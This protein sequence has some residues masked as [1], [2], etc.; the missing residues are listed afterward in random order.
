MAQKLRS[1]QEKK[2]GKVNPYL[3]PIRNKITLAAKISV[4]PSALKRH[5]GFLFLLAGFLSCLNLEARAEEYRPQIGTYGG[6][7]VFS[8]TSDPKSFN[9]I[10]AKETST[11]AVTGLIFEGLTRTNGIT[12]EVE[13]NLALSWKV[14]ESG[15]KWTFK[16]REDV[17]WFDGQRFTADDVV[18]TFNQLIYSPDIPNSA[19]D[20]FTVE[21]KTFKVEKVDD[22]R[23]SFT[24]PVKFAPF[25]RGMGQEILPKHILEDCVKK[26]RF[27]SKWTLNTKPQEI[28]GTGPFKLEKYEAGQR[29]ILRR[30]PD[31]WK[32][33]QEN[34]RLPYIEKII[35]LVVQNQDT[36]LLKF[37]EGELDYYG[38][39]GTDYPI[40]KPEEKKGNFTVYET[41][42]AFGTN[43]LVF[44][45]NR[46]QDPKTG[47]Q[48]VSDEKL[49]WFTNKKFRQAM[50]YCID[51]DSIINIVL[52]GLG[53]AQDAALSPSA[54]YF[55]NPNV[56]KYKY[57]L[58]KAQELLAQAGFSDSD[59]DGIIEDKEGNDVEFSLNTNSGNT[60]RVQIANIV[61]KDLEKVGFRVH[62]MQLEFNNLVVKLNSSYDWDAIILG[63]TGGIEPHFGNNVWQSSGQLHMWYPKQEK[64]ATS[65][66]KEIDEIFNQGVQELDKAKRKR[67]YDRWQEIVA[68]EVPFIYTVL[69]T[70]LFAVRNKFGNL[71]PTAYGGAFHNL[72]YIFV[73]EKTKEA[74]LAAGTGNRLFSFFE[75]MNKKPSK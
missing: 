34:N 35:F 67:L 20:I 26:G 72:E 65:W 64:P 10:L 56:K 27:N 17:L 57:D 75:K 43:F 55:Y 48:Y 37:K 59:E 31:Y 54:G 60:E 8:T 40:L 21:G 39:R 70:S 33:D 12:T 58:K 2:Y 24:L 41:G 29:I 53:S 50:A 7:L 47:K 13:P 1:N 42:P 4:A 36:A 49:S 32:T 16:L 23:V 38:L 74:G 18:F 5:W 73:Q 22:F 25:L 62:F 28:I 44:N 46:G 3:N 14:D 66:E 63:L 69:P 30:N 9:P 51:R 71:F 52:N 68:D 6:E 45:Q 15:L 19:R 61:R 11:T